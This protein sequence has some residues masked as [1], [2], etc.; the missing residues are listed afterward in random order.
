M[1]AV[2]HPKWDERPLLL[3]VPHPAGAAAVA[4]GRAG[5]HAGAGSPRSSHSPDGHSAS[6]CMHHPCDADLF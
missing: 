1:I 2:P 6:C 5:L 4:G 3:V